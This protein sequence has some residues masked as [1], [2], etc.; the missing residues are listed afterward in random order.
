MHGVDIRLHHFG[1]LHERPHRKHWAEKYNSRCYSGQCVFLS[2]P[3]TDAQALRVVVL[4]KTYR[5]VSKRKRHC[6]R[7]SFYQCDFL[8]VDLLFHNS[9]ILFNQTLWNSVYYHFSRPC[10]LSTSRQLG[11]IRKP[12]LL[13][14]I[15]R[16][17]K[18][19]LTARRAVA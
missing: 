16:S 4:T 9:I 5:F 6:E 17:T 12:Q 2:D 3:L 10:C 1:S 8:Q 7:T 11:W 13:F 14:F 18:L 15:Y 19:Q